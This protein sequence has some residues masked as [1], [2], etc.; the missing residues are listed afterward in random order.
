LGVDLSQLASVDVLLDSGVPVPY[1][2]GMRD[3]TPPFEVEAPPYF[4]SL[5]LRSWFSSISIVLVI[6]V[7]LFKDMY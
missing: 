7:S 4:I 5:A 3:G 2:L 6:Y 1:L